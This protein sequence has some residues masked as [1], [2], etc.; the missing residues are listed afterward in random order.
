MKPKKPGEQPSGANTCHRARLSSSGTNLSYNDG[1]KSFGT[2]L[3]TCPVLA[4]V[5]QRLALATKI[6]PRIH[7]LSHPDHVNPRACPPR[8]PC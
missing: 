8:L 6:H 5:Y 2:P 4:S 7:Q 3:G 1:A